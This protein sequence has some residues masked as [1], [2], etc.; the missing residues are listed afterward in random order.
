MLYFTLKSSEEVKYLRSMKR[1]FLTGAVIF[2]V[3]CANAFSP[4][5][6]ESAKALGATKGKYIRTGLVFVNGKF[7]RPPYIVERW[8]TGIRIN[9][10]PVTG[11]VVA[12]SDFLKTQDPSVVTATASAEGE[13]PPSD[14]AE[15]GGLPPPPTDEPPV[16][17]APEPPPAPAGV[18]A[19]SSSSDDV[20][21]L[22]DLFDSDASDDDVAQKSAPK[23]EAAS[24]PKPMPKAGTEKSRQKA[25][26]PVLKL[27]GKFVKN[28]ASKALV[29]KVNATRTEI[30]RQLRNGGL[31]CFG[32]H[33]AR[34]V[35]GAQAAAD[36]L[37]FLPEAQ[38][39]AT[40][41][42]DLQRRLRA[43]RLD[44]LHEL[45]VRDF[46]E[47]RIDYRRLQDHRKKLREDKEMDEM[48]ELPKPLF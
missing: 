26:S 4:I 8:G 43:A 3:A 15:A 20:L 21:S 5:P 10:T 12:W 2:A 13:L 19:D 32:D 22:D 14:D 33:Y 41:A 7:L 40:S 46:F 11:Q 27:T 45:I 30:D 34:I 48:L 31:L 38:M 25:A 6:K 16:E 9:K 23:P 47:N 24:A 1:L 39:K 42:E 18:T 35:G 29:K 44:Y 37:K 28:D 36:V 17:T